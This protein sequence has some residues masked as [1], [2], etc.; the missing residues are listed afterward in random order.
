MTTNGLP[1]KRATA[2]VRSQCAWTISAPRAARRVARHIERNRSGAS[3][4][5]RRMF[6]AIPPPV[7][8]PEVPVT[9]TRREH[10]HLHPALAQA[11]DGVGDETAGEF[12]LAPRPRS[13]EDDDPRSAGCP[14]ARPAKTTGSASAKARKA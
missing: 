9:G 14:R 7:R 10:L 1:A 13:R 3:H 11:F 2:A 12:P 6:A 5:R 4:G 8:E